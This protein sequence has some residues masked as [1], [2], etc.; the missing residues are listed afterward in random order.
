MTKWHYLL[1]P[2]KPRTFPGERWLDIGLRSIHLIG[3]AGIGGGFLLNVPE[4]QYQ[5]FWQLTMATGSLLVLL[6]V[7][8]DGKWLLRVK[9]IVILLK[10]FLLLL[11]SLLPEWRAAL[12]SLIILM[13][14]WVAHAPGKVRGFSPFTN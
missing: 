5:P 6:Y 8:T 7:W 9:G 10:L 4:A 11:A 14:G 13:S 3:I 1:F 2:P 12:F